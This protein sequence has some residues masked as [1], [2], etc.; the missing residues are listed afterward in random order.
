MLTVTEV[1][2]CALWKSRA[3]ESRVEERGTLSGIRNA[4]WVNDGKMGKE[5][6]R[7]I[8]ITKRGLLSHFVNTWAL[9]RGKFHRYVKR[10]LGKINSRKRELHT[11]L[12]L[13]ASKLESF[14]FSL[15]F[16]S[17]FFS[18][19]SLHLKRARAFARFH[20]R[21]SNSALTPSRIR[22]GDPHSRIVHAAD[23]TVS[24]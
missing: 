16:F 20:T 10:S 6:E 18:Y 3:S 9:Y 5:K 7:V 4:M 15:L 8:S 19:E 2:S 24:T 13:S 21:V 12:I 23:R 1:T 22:V 17:F 14:L 11:R